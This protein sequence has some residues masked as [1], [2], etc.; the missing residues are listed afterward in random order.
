MSTFTS[1]LTYSNP[2]T[3]ASPV[4]TFES[5]LPNL[6]S[7]QFNHGNC[8]CCPHL[9]RLILAKERSGFGGSGGFDDEKFAG[10]WRRDG[11]LPDL[12]SRGGPR[13]GRPDGPPSRE[14]PPSTLADN[15]SDWRSS[16]GPAHA[17]PPEDPSFKRR[18]PGFRSPEA[19]SLGP[20]DTEDT[21]A[22]GSRFKPSGPPEE[23]SPG[24]RFGSLRGGPPRE[25]PSPPEEDNWRRPRPGNSTSRK[26]ALQG[27]L[28]VLMISFSANNS[29]PPT[30][31]LSRRK[32]ELLPRS[33]ANS[34][35]P[36][37]LSSPNPA[38]VAPAARSNPF[39]A[40]KYV[41]SYLSCCHRTDK[42]LK[43]DR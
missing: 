7:H 32:L 2:S 35:V 11:P 40:A 39:G 37:P 1:A 22:K 30:P 27:L 14:P 5:A 26:L 31:Q 41:L 12:P 43:I 24:P 42:I 17:P 15:A 33:S 19:T 38:A 21:W 3:R 23:R 13:G 6:V 28:D 10:N 29:T 16:R 8:C 9:H 25:T 4:A 34:A 18:G 20:A 36:S